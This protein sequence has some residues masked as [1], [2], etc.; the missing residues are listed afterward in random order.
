MSILELILFYY[1][2]NV[3]LILLQYYINIISI[4]LIVVSIENFSDFIV[5]KLSTKLNII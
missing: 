5:F 3:M 4:Y 1:Y 2:A